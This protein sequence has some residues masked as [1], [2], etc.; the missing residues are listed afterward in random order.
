MYNVK[1]TSVTVG[2]SNTTI[3]TWSRE[4]GD[5]LSA[6]A[7][8]ERGQVRVYSDDDIAVFTTVKVLRSQHQTFDAI[9]KRLA[10]GERLEPV[11]QESPDTPEAPP[12]RADS[13]ESDGSMA[14]APADLLERFMVQLES[15]NEARIAAEIR[16]STAEGQNVILKLELS[17]ARRSW[18]DRLRGW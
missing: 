6:G 1:L 16:A 12:E 5:F 10:T 2:V 4:F 11:P 3:R 15:S 17:R 13:D 9:H 7:N 14:L 8:P 18:W